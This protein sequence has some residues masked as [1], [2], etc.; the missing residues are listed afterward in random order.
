MT[1]KQLSPSYIQSAQL[2]HRRIDLL[3]RQERNAADAETRRRLQR[4]IRDLQPLE[5]E[6]RRLANHTDRYYDRGYHRYDC[7]TV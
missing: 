5:T 1:L 4:R 6:C 3:R 7:Y 2:I